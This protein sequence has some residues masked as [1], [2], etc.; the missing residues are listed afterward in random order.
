MTL[1]YDS[2]FDNVP[3]TL[4]HKKR[5]R[6][7]LRVKKNLTICVVLVMALL[8]TSCSEAGSTKQIRATLFL[9]DASGSMIRSVSEREQQ[10]KERLN[11]A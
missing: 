10:L 6:N 4:T 7:A 11:G 5:K 2:L 1:L 3:M 9:L 8:L